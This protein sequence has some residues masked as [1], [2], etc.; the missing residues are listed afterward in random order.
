MTGNPD[1]PRHTQIV[2]RIKH[3]ILNDVQH[4]VL[5]RLPATFAALHDHVDANT[6]GGLCDEHADIDT[7][8]LVTIQE[9]IVYERGQLRPDLRLQGIGE[10]RL[11]P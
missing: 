9:T 2:E 1:L 4:G 5:P 3:E 11:T 8:E 10:V 6:Y 7:D